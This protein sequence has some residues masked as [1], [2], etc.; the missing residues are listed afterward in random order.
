MMGPL[1]AF[2]TAA[3]PA[4]SPDA[5]D[6]ANRLVGYQASHLLD[7]RPST[8]WRADGD[9]AGQVLTFTFDRPR[10][11]TTAGLVNGYA[12]VDPVTGADRY[13]QSRRITQVTWTIEGQQIVQELVGHDREAQTVSFPPVVTQQVSMR[14]DDVTAPGDPRFD[15]TVISD[16]VLADD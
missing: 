11:I 14:I 15:Q 7:G 3:V 1:E 16:V 13:A 6:G 10:E 2:A 9:L 4:T 8:A 12:K 5:V